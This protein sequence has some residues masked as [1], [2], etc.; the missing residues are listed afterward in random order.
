MEITTTQQCVRVYCD[1]QVLNVQPLI[2]LTQN[3]EG[4][5]MEVNATANKQEIL[6]AIQSAIATLNGG[7]ATAT[8][9]AIM[10]AVGNIDFSTL[11]KQG[12]NPLATNT[13]I[14]EA[15][16][17]IDFS[18]VAKQGEDSSVSLTSINLRLT[19]IFAQPMATTAQVAEM[20]AEILTPYKNE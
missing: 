7:D 11:A 20:D 5:A 6:A 15:F 16:G 19:N 14:L 2:V 4:V 9:A 12:D 10:Q 1:D 3:L 8:L 13:A 18:S 17:S